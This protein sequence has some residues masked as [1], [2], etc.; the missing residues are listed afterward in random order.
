MPVAGASDGPAP[1]SA[2]SPHGARSR[3]AARRPCRVSTSTKSCSRG[4]SGFHSSTYGASP[5]VP[6]SRRRKTEVVRA[7][8][9]GA[10]TKPSGRRRRARPAPA[11]ATRLACRERVARHAAGAAITCS[12]STNAAM[13]R[14]G[15][16][17]REIGSTSG[18]ENALARGWRPPTASSRRPSSARRRPGRYASAVR[19]ERRP[20]A[21]REQLGVLPLQREHRAQQRLVA[22]VPAD[23]RAEDVLPD[24]HAD[25]VEPRALQLVEVAAVPAARVV[26]HVPLLEPPRAEHARHRRCRRTTAPTRDGGRRSARAAASTRPRTR[27]RPARVDGG[28][29]PGRRLLHRVEEDAVGVEFPHERA[30]S[31]PSS[32]TGSRRVP[33]SH[34]L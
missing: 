5:Y 22:L 19:G 4:G 6:V 13:P 27:R 31:P 25:A 15:S 21:G 1:S 32:S 23:P 16:V 26:E 12:T 11:R 34:G 2:S 9:R 3:T 33:T 10:S 17:D 30:R 24:E 29:Q 20:L 28:P 8:G 18:P 7:G 14:A